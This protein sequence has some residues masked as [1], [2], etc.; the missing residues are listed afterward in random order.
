MPARGKIG[1]LTHARN[2]FDLINLTALT[3]WPRGFQNRPDNAAISDG[4]C[5]K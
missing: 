4:N 2:Q 3:L 5:V 1:G